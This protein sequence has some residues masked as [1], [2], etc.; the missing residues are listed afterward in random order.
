MYDNTFSQLKNCVISTYVR[1]LVITAAVHLCRT[2]CTKIKHNIQQCKAQETPGW[3]IGADSLCI[4]VFSFIVIFMSL[5]WSLH[6]NHKSYTLFCRGD[7]FITTMIQCG[8]LEIFVKSLQSFQIFSSVCKAMTTVY[9]LYISDKSTVT[10]QPWKM[11]LLPH[12]PALHWWFLNTNVR[13]WHQYHIGELPART[14][15]GSSI[16]YNC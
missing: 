14:L 9:V 15:L 13:V 1:W 16:F 11:T 10:K 12:L 8:W 5:K 7:S 2:H 6:L 4:C 3:S